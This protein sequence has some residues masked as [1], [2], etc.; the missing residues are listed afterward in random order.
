MNHM[1]ERERERWRERDIEKLDPK[2]ASC[3]F[4]LFCCTP[5]E[6]SLD[7]ASRLTCAGRLY[8]ISNASQ[9]FPQYHLRPKPIV[10]PSTRNVLH[11]PFSYTS[12]TR[13]PRLVYC[14][15]LVSKPTYTRISKREHLIHFARYCKLVIAWIL[16]VSTRERAG[17]NA[18][19]VEIHLGKLTVDPNVVYP[20]CCIW[21]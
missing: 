8:L 13:L 11:H 12:Q 21:V 16:E 3:E 10:P 2:G 20:L 9:P 19:G 1:S 15:D 5:Q 7:D 6:T 17:R 14:S 18:S 4:L